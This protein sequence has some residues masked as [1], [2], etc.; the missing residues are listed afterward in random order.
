MWRCGREWWVAS[1]RGDN[2]QPPEQVPSQEGLPSPA[3]TNAPGGARRSGRRRNKR[4]QSPQEPN[5]G[6]GTTPNNARQTETGAH[7]DRHQQGSGQLPHAPYVAAAEDYPTVKDAPW[8]DGNPPAIF[9]LGY[10]GA[11][12]TAKDGRPAQNTRAAPGP[13]SHP[14]P[15]ASL[16]SSPSPGAMSEGLNPHAASEPPP[17]ATSIVP[18]SPASNGLV[19][20]EDEVVPRPVQAGPRSSAPVTEAPPTLL[21]FS[22]GLL[23]PLG[24]PPLAYRANA[25]PHMMQQGTYSQPLPRPLLQAGPAH[26][27]PSVLQPLGTHGLHVSQQQPGWGMTA[28]QGL[29]QP[30]QQTPVWQPGLQQSG[31]EHPRPRGR[32][33]GPAQAD[34]SQSQGANLAALGENLS[35]LGSSPTLI[36]G[37]PMS[38]AMSFAPAPRTIEGIPGAAPDDAT[39]RG[40]LGALPVVQALQDQGLE[41]R[42]LGF[43]PGTPRP[44]GNEVGG[45]SSAAPISPQTVLQGIRGSAPPMFPSAP[46]GHPATAPSP[47]G[48]GAAHFRENG[49]G[50]PVSVPGQPT[51]GSNLVE[52]FLPSE[53]RR[54]E[55][56]PPQ[57]WS[58]SLSLRPHPCDHTPSHDRCCGGF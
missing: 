27:Q 43:P 41:Q 46:Q 35:A 14:S 53:A 49:S 55:E 51:F 25:A 2:S 9:A 39:G 33:Q 15:P 4:G 56:Q 18:S 29:H 57:G 26:M 54:P 30:R 22:Q 32:Q 12:S 5:S 40:R 31:W 42:H 36:N 6:A 24:S 37:Y 44:A 10:L 13:N 1:S 48:P 21:A 8:K 20:I 58:E 11:E 16:A 38:G 3:A 45:P 23:P 50:A 47:W 19:S 34:L 7:H 52:R 17:S 28:F